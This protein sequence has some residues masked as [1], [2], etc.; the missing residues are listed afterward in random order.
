MKYLQLYF[1]KQTTIMKAF[2]L[3]ALIIIGLAL[4]S[5]D[6]NQENNV[7][8]EPIKVA[9][10]KTKEKKDTPVSNDV[11]VIS[12]VGL[13]TAEVLFLNNPMDLNG[14]HGI[15]EIIVIS[16]NGISNIK[17]SE[18]PVISINFTDLGV[19]EDD[20]IFVDIRH[21]SDVKPKIFNPEQ[22]HL[23]GQN[24]APY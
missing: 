3:T 23:R 18:A 11:E 7:K 2:G 13:N 20:Q 17:Y 21:S 12:L 24:T 14:A 19:S 4:I 9:L 15:K 5:M 10:K 16:S 1:F 8:D 22:F 6:F